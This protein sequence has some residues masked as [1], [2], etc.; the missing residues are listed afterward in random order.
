VI[1]LNIEIF[2]DGK[3][4]IKI[5]VK[6]QLGSEALDEFEAVYQKIINEKNGNN[7]NSSTIM[8]QAVHQLRK[9]YG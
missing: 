8:R 3:T 5:D 9:K 2:V 1:K 6:D 4:W 7:V